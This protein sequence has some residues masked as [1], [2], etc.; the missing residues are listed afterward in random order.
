MR[1]PL[2][3]QDF[4]LGILL[5]GLMRFLQIAVFLLLGCMQFFQLVLQFPNGFLI[6]RLTGSRCVNLIGDGIA[7][8]LM[9]YLRV[10]PC[11]LLRLQSEV[12]F[13]LHFADFLSN[14]GAWHTKYEHQC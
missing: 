9:P 7:F 13:L 4:K 3:Q 8:P 11:L 14:R 2:A 6:H 12:Q 10:L 1:C 5:S